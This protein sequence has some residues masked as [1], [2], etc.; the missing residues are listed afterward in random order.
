[1]AVVRKPDGHG[2]VLLVVEELRDKIPLVKLGV[3][4]AMFNRLFAVILLLEFFI[5]II[6]CPGG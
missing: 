6:I 2:M 3:G 1:M 5:I 4:I